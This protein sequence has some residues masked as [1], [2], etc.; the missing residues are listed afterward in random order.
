[1]ALF[2]ASPVFL[3]DHRIRLAHRQL[4]ARLLLR[5]ARLLRGLGGLALANKERLALLGGL[6]LPG[7]RAR[8]VGGRQLA[9][10]EAL[11]LLGAKRSRTGLGLRTVA[12]GGFRVSLRGL[13]LSH[14]IRHLARRA[15]GRVLAERAERLERVLSCHDARQSYLK[16]TIVPAS[17]PGLRP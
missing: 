14:C 3:D 1:L 10:F 12:L 13:A 7:V 15:I 4:C 6:V 11:R 16:R 17:S 5:R 2:P 9:T 8:E